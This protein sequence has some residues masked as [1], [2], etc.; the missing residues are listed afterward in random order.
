MQNL[1]YKLK[2][3]LRYRYIRTFEIIDNK[4]GEITYTQKLGGILLLQLAPII[5][6][7]DDY[8]MDEFLNIIDLKVSVIKIFAEDSIFNVYLEDL[9]AI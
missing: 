3:D 5:H 9:V 7:V 6:N 4:V 2:D 1:L 8:V